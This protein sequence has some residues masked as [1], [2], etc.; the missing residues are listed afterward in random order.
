MSGLTV[1]RTETL[2]RNQTRE[3][4][5][6]RRFGADPNR[7][8]NTSPIQAAIAAVPEGTILNI[9]AEDY[10]VPS[11]SSWDL[12][13][14][15]IIQ[16]DGRLIG[17]GGNFLQCKPGSSL[18]IE[19]GG[20]ENWNIPIRVELPVNTLS[21]TGVHFKDCNRAIWDDNAGE[22]NGAM[23]RLLVSR[24]TFEDMERY[25]I[26]LRTEKIQHGL[27][28][29]SIFRNIGDNLEGT[30]A[31]IQVGEVSASEDEPVGRI[32]IQGNTIDGVTTTSSS[33]QC[34]GILASSKFVTIRNNYLH[35]VLG[36]M[37]NADNEAIYTKGLFST[38][39]G[40]TV[41]NC[42]RGEA[43]LI[44]K[45]SS[46]ETNPINGSF[47]SRITNNTVIARDGFVPSTYAIR[48]SGSDAI[49][50]GN[51][52]ENWSQ[53]IEISGD[54]NWVRNNRLRLNA[55]NSDG[56]QAVR[57]VRSS[58]ILIE[59]NEC[60][61]M[62]ENGGNEMFLRIRLEC[63]NIV[64]RANTVD[65]ASGSGGAVL[66]QADPGDEVKDIEIIG[67]KFLGNVRSGLNWSGD[68]TVSDVVW[69]N[70]QDNGYD[71]YE[72][73]DTLYPVVRRGTISGTGSPEG[74]V[75]APVGTIYIRL[76]GGA[77]TT[78]YVKE[79]GT[80]NTGWVAK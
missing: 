48:V 44:I 72:I 8:D 39:D 54:Y 60:P 38:I 50:E 78:L 10:H 2:L 58:N 35:N 19:G 66:I 70:N 79:S 24:C 30:K 32:I 74:V 1:P 65:M 49:V 3:V 77:D 4:V 40:N 37:G 46:R 5:S 57:L 23:E 16:C 25:G 34:R 75:A 36:G 15:L 76:D 47:G 18:I 59:N 20:F 43:C 61:G 45:G 71:W 56:K 22:T 21:L 42:S 31:A 14:S 68:G 7:A 9:P 52:V 64:V 63:Q 80:G 73:R 12:A 55:N 11:W 62:G 67:N 69:E 28:E 6:V 33:E 26:L 13:K 41:V 27:I 29:N 53:G 17:D 51:Q